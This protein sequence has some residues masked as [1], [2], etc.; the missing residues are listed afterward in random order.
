MVARRAGHVLELHL[1]GGG[2]HRV[3]GLTKL[4]FQELH[5]AAVRGVFGHNLAI[6]RVRIHRQLP[7]RPPHVL[8]QPANAPVVVVFVL[9]A[10]NTADPAERGGQVDG[11][12]LVLD[13]R[14]DQRLEVRPRRVF[15]PCALHHW[16]AHGAQQAQRP[17]VTVQ[18]VDRPE[19]PLEAVELQQS[20]ALG[21]GVGLLVQ[22]RVVPEDQHL[23]VADV[24]PL[25]V[26]IVVT[27]VSGGVQVSQQLADVR[28]EPV[29]GIRLTW[30]S[31]TVREGNDVHLV[32]R[33][34]S[35]VGG[36]AGQSVA[37]REHEGNARALRLG[38][39]LLQPRAL[40]EANARL[41]ATP[42]A[43]T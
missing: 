29:L 32:L 26:R 36:V 43:E 39:C 4:L 5:V 41:R 35:R 7:R 17:D 22:A 8:E 15:V 11:S 3:E 12:V 33:D 42:L 40:Q 10:A 18:D 2:H 1:L 30:A 27:E 16:I 9:V 28:E 34:G 6:E 38:K 31:P 20:H 24:Q 25:H 21:R 13:Q 14:R 23:P 37:G 19:A